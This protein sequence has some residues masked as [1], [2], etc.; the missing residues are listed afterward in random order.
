MKTLFSLLICLVTYPAFAQSPFR[1]E[2]ET[3]VSSLRLPAPYRAGWQVRQ[4]LTAYVRPRLGI[5]LG[6]G[7]GGS[8][9]NDPL[10]AVQNKYGQPD[11]NALLDY[12][13]R[14]ESMTDL[15]AVWLPLLTRR[16]QLKVQVGLSLQRRREVNI[17]SI[18]REQQ[19]DPYYDAFPTYTDQS[20]VMP[21]V[22]LGYDYRLSPRWSVGVNAVAY[23]PASEKAITTFGLRTSY[24]FNISRDSLGTSAGFIEPLTWGVR[25]AASRVGDNGSSSAASRNVTKFV[26]GLWAEYPLSLTWAMRG[27][28]NYAQRGYRFDGYKTSSGS[29]SALTVEATYLEVPLLFRHEAADRLHLYAG[30]YLAFLLDGTSQQ[31][32]KPAVSTGAHTNTGLMFGADFKFSKSLSLDL[33]YQRDLIQ[34]STS[35][36]SNTFHSYQLGVNWAVR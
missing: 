13:N 4:Q 22:A 9:N 21:M 20:R 8:A 17:D 15:S 1:F 14:Q 7:W 11:P 12:Y 29:A 6:M 36:Y 23:L 32:G 5:A 25:V 18:F 2:A 3:G 28:F 16:H 10:N 33:R 24:R 30:P 19:N 27:E 31:E 34:L 26:A 35:P